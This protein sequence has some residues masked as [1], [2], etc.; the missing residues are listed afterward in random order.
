VA[1][2]AFITG[3]HAL[4][5]CRMASLSGYL[6]ER[7]TLLFVVAGSIPAAAA[8]L[9]LG[10]RLRPITSARILTAAAVVAGIAV[11]APALAKPMHGNRAGHKAA[12]LWLADHITANDGILDPFCWAEFYAGRL[13]WRVTTDRPERLFVVLET[14]DN[15]H[16]RLPHIPDAKAKATLGELVYHWPENRPAEQAQVVVYSVPGDRLPDPARINPRPEY[17]VGLKAA[18]P[19]AAGP[20][21]GRG[22]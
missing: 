18:S 7:H 1:V 5:L 3:L 10:D 14:S 13:E 17:R 20:P 6:S 12:G 19:T 9:W 21:T 4:I 22:G 11:A 16:S 2:L 15:Q 8:L